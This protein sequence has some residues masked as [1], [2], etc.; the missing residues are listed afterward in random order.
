MEAAC[1]GGDKEVDRFPVYIVCFGRRVVVGK[2]S[3]LP[4]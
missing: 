3:S 1:H 4:D 2:G